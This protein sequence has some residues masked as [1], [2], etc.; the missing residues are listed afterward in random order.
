MNE[1]YEMMRLEKVGENKDQEGRKT[2]AGA[3]LVN[4]ENEDCEEGS[5]KIQKNRKVVVRLCRLE[6]NEVND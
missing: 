5:E 6:N 2:V 1:R 4:S 3:T